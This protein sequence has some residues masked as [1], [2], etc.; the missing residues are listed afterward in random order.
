M[1]FSSQMEASPVSSIILSS[2]LIGVQTLHWLYSD[3]VNFMETSPVITWK[4]RLRM[5]GLT[6]FLLTLDINLAYYSY[7]M[8]IKKKTF[9]LVFLLELGLCFLLHLSALAKS[10]NKFLEDQPQLLL[11]MQLFPTQHASFAHLHSVLPPQHRSSF[12]FTLGK[13][14]FIHDVHQSHNRLLPHRHQRGLFISL[15]NSQHFPI[16]PT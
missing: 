2:C 9:F 7:E 11:P 10:C 6:V 5:I 1:I 3:R 4:Y 12:L 14:K 15:T 8:Y 13:Q 16:I